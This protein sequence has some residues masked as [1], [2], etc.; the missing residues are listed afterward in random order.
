MKGVT[1]GNYHSFR[2]FRLV[3]SPNNAIG[4]PAPKYQKLDIPGGDGVLDFTEAFGEVKYGNRSLS[5]EFS[6]MVPQSEFMALFAT[7]QNALHGQKMRIVLDDD[8][9]SYYIGRLTVSEW[10]ADRLIG[11]LTIDCDC[12]PWRF[13]PKAQ[14]VHVVG[15]NLIDLGAA[16]IL[17]EG[18][19]TK[20]QNGFSFTRGTGAGGSF[21]YWMVPVKKGQE[22]IFSASY[23]LTT[24]LLYVYK[25]RPYGTLVVKEQSGNPCTFTADE[26]GLYVFGCYVTS[27]ATDGTFANIMLCEGNKV[28]TFE[29]YNTTAHALT[30]TFT[31]T[32]KRAAVPTAYTSGKITAETG[33]TLSTLSPGAQSI[34]EFTFYPGVEKTLT[35]K[36]TGY[37]VI[38]WLERGL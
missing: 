21:V 5:F 31:N 28:G 30:L 9:D 17:G 24:R 37:A 34:P 19:W 2:D 27:S 4:T 15:R 14:T 33:A 16:T 11:S 1:F 26:T 38:G 10:K 22:Y 29:L 23:T 6:T 35:F 18:T 13:T 25:D 32:G 36:G 3:L 7:V 20:T 8:P 12:E